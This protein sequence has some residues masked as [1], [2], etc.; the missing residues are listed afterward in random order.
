MPEETQASWLQEPHDI[1]ISGTDVGNISRS[2]KLAPLVP[3]SQR[4]LLSP[5]G[6]RSRIG[7][8][9]FSLFEVPS[10]LW[11]L[12]SLVGGRTVV[13]KCVIDMYPRQVA[14]RKE[15]KAKGMPFVS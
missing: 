4:L 7:D 2:T 6:V 8:T 9:G 3:V 5:P 12:Q 10:Y 14:V 11:K 13:W 15:H 1:L